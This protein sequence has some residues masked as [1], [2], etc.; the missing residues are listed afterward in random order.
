M[1]KTVMLFLF[2][3][4]TATLHAAWDGK[5]HCGSYRGPTITHSC[6]VNSSISG[7][8]VARDAQ[9]LRIVYATRDGQIDNDS[10]CADQRKGA[11]I[12]RECRKEAVRIF[13][14]VCKD[15]RSDN[16]YC[17]ASRNLRIVE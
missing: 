4:S 13:K 2:L 6:Y 16:M 9:V 14:Q 3:A 15:Q 5:L 11:I 10:V 7:I 12:R 1:H 8:G 17:V